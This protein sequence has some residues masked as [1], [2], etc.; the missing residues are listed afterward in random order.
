MPRFAHLALERVRG[1][2][3]RGSKLIQHVVPLW[4]RCLRSLLR[5]WQRLGSGPI[6]TAAMLTNTSSMFTHF[7]LI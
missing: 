1:V 3:R 7:T 4:R 5:G 6:K 2:I